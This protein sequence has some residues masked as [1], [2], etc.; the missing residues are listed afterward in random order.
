MC[1]LPRSLPDGST[2]E[3]ETEYFSVVI[4]AE[5]LPAAFVPLL[6]KQLELELDAAVEASVCLWLSRPPDVCGPKDLGDLAGD[7]KDPGGTFAGDEQES[8]LVLGVVCF[9]LWIE[10]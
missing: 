6:V 3:S 9:R 1:Q 2:W 7:L 8:R 4:G 10:I 5:H